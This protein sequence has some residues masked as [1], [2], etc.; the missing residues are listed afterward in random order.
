MFRELEA[1]TADLTQSLEKQTA[2]AEVLK[3]ISDSPTDTQPVFDTIAKLAE[4][5]CAADLSIVSRFDGELIQL[6]GTP[7]H[8]R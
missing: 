7:R 2:T 4:K 1:R 5:L 3:V 6:V 8:G